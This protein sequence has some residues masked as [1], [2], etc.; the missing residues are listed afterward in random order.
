MKIRKI[1][2][3]A[4]CQAT[5]TNV[6]P[7]GLPNGW[8]TSGKRGE[9]WSGCVGAHFTFWKCQVKPGLQL[10]YK[11]YVYAGIERESLSLNIDRV[12]FSPRRQSVGQK[13]RRKKSDVRMET[14]DCTLQATTVEEANVFMA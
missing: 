14:V 2:S 5:Q 4:G 13:D 3:T 12:R 9:T 11:L 8:M 1:R 7:R 6:S 10:D